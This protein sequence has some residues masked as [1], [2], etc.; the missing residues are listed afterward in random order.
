[1][2][3]IESSAELD[4]AGWMAVRMRSA[5]AGAAVNTAMA[6]LG[7]ALSLVT[8][9]I[10]L[11]Y[12]G[13]EQ[14]GLMLLLVTLQTYLGQTNLG[15]NWAAMNMIGAARATGDSREFVTVVQN[16]TLLAL[17]TAGVALTISVGLAA[18]SQYGLAEALQL[19][20][21]VDPWAIVAVGMLSA[22]SLSG[23][24]I[25]LTFLG[26]GQSSTAAL[27]QGLGRVLSIPAMA[28]V[29]YRGGGIAAMFAANALIVFGLLVIAGAHLVRRFPSLAREG[30]HL[31]RAHCRRQLSMGVK[32]MSAE[33][34]YMLHATAP[35]IALGATCGAAAVPLYAVPRTLME[36]ALTFG[37]AQFS[38]LQPAYAEAVRH[39]RTNAIAHMLSRSLTRNLTLLGVLCAGFIVLS[40][41]FV[42][43]WTSGR[44]GVDK[45]TAAAIAAG[46]SAIFLVQMFQLFL[47]AA[48]RQLLAAR[49]LVG[50]G[51]VLLGAALIAGWA[52]GFRGVLFVAAAGELAIAA[53]MGSRAWK[54]LGARFPV[55]RAVQKVAS[56]G[57]LFAI[58]L[59]LGLLLNGAT[60][61]RIMPS[62]RIA[63]VGAAMTASYGLLL[64]S[65]SRLNVAS[66]SASTVIGS[67]S[68]PKQKDDDV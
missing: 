4:D 63:L 25:Y 13:Q 44:L 30:P 35:T 16:A 34:G 38:I 56:V 9:P 14:Y 47:I 37:R 5:N 66:H 40:G 29:A 60:E 24:P 64:L 53:L 54:Q 52:T 61:A 28:T 3:A 15:L 55:S 17:A 42:E 23:G 41:P 32:N 12:L 27:Y 45:A 20:G 36:A 39:G 18:A 49:L 33:L 22:L 2:S 1:M 65:L 67:P 58:T 59:T 31:S 26:M 6:Y 10:Y 8:V 57:S 51:V 68:A 48:D 43:L 62:A 11:K 21:A 19:S 46:S 7:Q 50:T